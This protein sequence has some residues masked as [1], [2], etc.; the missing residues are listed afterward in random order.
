MFTTV[1]KVLK[2]C[3]TDEYGHDYELTGISGTVGFIVGMAL[4]A[5]SQLTTWLPKFDL[6]QYATGFS[7]LVIATGISQRVKP[8]AIVPDVSKGP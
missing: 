1:K 2:D 6:V 8:A 7:A 3:S 5:V 4:Y